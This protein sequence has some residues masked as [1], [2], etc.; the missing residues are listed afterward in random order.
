[1]C[2]R[3]PAVACLLTR[4]FDRIGTA[5]TNAA[6]AAPPEAP[7][8][9]SAASEGLGAKFGLPEASSHDEDGDIAHEQLGERRRRNEDQGHSKCTAVLESMPYQINIEYGSGDGGHG[10][11]GGGKSGDAGGGG[12]ED[13]AAAAV[14][15]SADGG[16]G[17]DN[18]HDGSLASDFFDQLYGTVDD[19]DV[20]FRLLLEG[21]AALTSTARRILMETVLS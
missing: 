14:A 9:S 16:G 4:A 7:A 18:D 1:Q 13:A 19:P 2:C 3:V 5:A 11:G 10:C 21:R 12:G 6:A 15:S 17:G 20:V 8:G